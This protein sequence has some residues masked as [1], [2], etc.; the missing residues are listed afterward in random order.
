MPPIIDGPSATNAD[1]GSG[2]SDEDIINAALN[3][4]SGKQADDAPDDDE[5]KPQGKF[6][7]PGQDKA[8]PKP[9]PV[10]DKDSKD[11]KEDDEPPVRRAPK[12]KN[13]PAADG[14]ADGDESQEGE[15]DGEDEEEEQEPETA[16]EEIQGGRPSLK[17]VK[18]KYPQIFKSFPGLKDIY[19]REIA[20]QRVFPTVHEATVA[21]Q[22]A[23]VLSSIRDSII[24]G[25][26]S[27]LAAAIKEESPEALKKFGGEILRT[28]Y[29]ADQDAYW[30]AVNPLVQKMARTLYKKGTDTGNQD[31]QYAAM[32]FAEFFAGDQDVATGGKSIVNEAEQIARKAIMEHRQTAKKEAWGSF[33][34]DTEQHAIGTLKGEIG[35]ALEKE[36]DIPDFFRGQLVDQIYREVATQL[37]ADRGHLQR[38]DSLWK[39]AARTMS[40][41]DKT[42][43]TTA[44]LARA[45]QLI[46]TSRNKLLTQMRGQ[47]SSVAKTDKL[48]N[49]ADRREPRQ[50][51]RTGAPNNAR[52]DSKNV[53]YDKMSDEEIISGSTKR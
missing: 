1:D 12:T 11:D 47:T 26:S 48:R 17:D 5:R 42:S 25:D 7:K 24:E 31:M 2:Q 22:D 38:M 15:G 6:L 23:E 39:K 16:P 32:Y 19:Y 53:N 14:N 40:Q 9:R 8:E 30:E 50:Q 36:S 45:K 18:A 20:Y 49:I 10:S 33:E 34:R 27:A 52:I 41:A 51:G 4:A 46:T 28:L 43:I 21:A 44:Y 13:E 29:A 3:P 35:K 37:N